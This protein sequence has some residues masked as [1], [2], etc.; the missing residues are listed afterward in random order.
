MYS[1]NPGEDRQAVDRAY[2]IGQ[3]KDVVV[4]RFIMASTVEEKMYEKQV[5]FLRKDSSI[6]NVNLA[7][8]IYVYI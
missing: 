3:K 8:N 6:V 2:R 4:Y 1:W 5:P 7:I